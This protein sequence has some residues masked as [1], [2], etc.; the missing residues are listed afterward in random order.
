MKGN[1]CI[2]Q[3]FV[4][5]MTVEKAFA[6]QRN[7]NQRLWTW[8]KIETYNKFDKTEDHELIV[9]CLERGK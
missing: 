7:M 9:Y 6:K 3:T 4:R 5:R 1:G 8:R 2:A